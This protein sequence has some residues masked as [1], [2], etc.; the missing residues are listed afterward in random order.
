MNSRTEHSIQTQGANPHGKPHHSSA[1]SEGKGQRDLN[2]N[3]HPEERTLASLGIGINKHAGYVLSYGRNLTE[4]AVSLVTEVINE[5]S[6]SQGSLWQ[7]F[8]KHNC[9]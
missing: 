4:L 7:G 3:T 9:L 6:P 5:R 8:R 1:S 2:N